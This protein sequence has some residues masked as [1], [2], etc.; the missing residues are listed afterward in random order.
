[1][2]RGVEG[3]CALEGTGTRKKAESPWWQDWP[4]LPQGAALWEPYLSDPMSLGQV[5][6]CKG[7]NGGSERGRDSPRSGADLTPL[8]GSQ[9]KA[10]SVIVKLAQH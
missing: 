5:P 2:V 9:F 7:G 3:A 6:P 8:L 4:K 1:M 10:L